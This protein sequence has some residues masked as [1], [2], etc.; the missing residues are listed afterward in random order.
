M[1]GDDNHYFIVGQ[2]E[3]VNCFKYWSMKT[4][5]ACEDDEAEKVPEATDIDKVDVPNV[6]NESA[7]LWFEF[8]KLISMINQAVI[9]SEMKK[10]LKAAEKAEKKL[11]DAMK[12]GTRE[13]QQ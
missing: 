13:G 7:D 6:A 3:V 4:S 11:I 12:I 8:S 1:P 5:T 2:E 10:Y 9:E